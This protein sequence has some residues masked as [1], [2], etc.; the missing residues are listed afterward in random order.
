[1]KSWL[2]SPRFWLLFILVATVG[3]LVYWWPAQPVLGWKAPAPPSLKV[4]LVPGKLLTFA[5]K[6]AKEPEDVLP[7]AGGSYIISCDDG[8]LRE[9]IPRGLLSVLA[10]TGGRPLGLAHGPDNTILV[11]DA[12]KGLLQVERKGKWKVLVDRF[13]KE[14][15]GYVDDVVMSKD[16]RSVYFTTASS[17]IS[18]QQDARFDILAFEP[19]G[20]LFRYDLSTKKLTMLLK[21][22]YFANGVT[23][24]PK[25][26]F[27]LVN[28][29][30]HYRTRRYWLKGEKKG[31][32]DI[33]TRNYPGYPD[34]I[35]PRKG[36]GYWVAL[37]SPRLKLVDRILHPVPFLKKLLFTVPIALWPP[38]GPV[39]KFLETDAN[40]KILK[41]W[42]L[43]AKSGFTN[44]TTVRE[45]KGTLLLGHIYRH[46]RGFGI[47]KRSSL[48]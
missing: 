27:V 47:I 35:R 16:K 48:R 10:N 14:K 20:R 34:N 41:V 42:Q 39:G 13:G 15:L 26:D 5:N 45:H 11:A 38:P 28:E 22:L 18:W 21:G 17:R 6:V 36:G 4:H 7:L 9:V 44:I 30:S 33:F 25:E 40:G 31:K 8:T 19:T 3:H 29:T 24:S 1:M 2:K 32:S 12:V 37:A 23:L 43:P 46:Q